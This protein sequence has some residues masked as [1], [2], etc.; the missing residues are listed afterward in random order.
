MRWKT[1]VLPVLAGS[2]VLGYLV[3]FACVVSEYEY[4]TLYWD[5]DHTGRERPIV[6]RP[7]GQ[8]FLD[9]ERLIYASRDP[10]LNLA[11]YYFYYPLHKLL[12]V[13]GVATFIRDMS[14]IA[15]G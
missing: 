8:C 14:T 6:K 1:R 11:A 3:S 5:E 15:F 9:G 4:T 2:L 10:Q 12:Q 7:D 13:A